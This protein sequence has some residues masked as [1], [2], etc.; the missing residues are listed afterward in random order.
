MSVQAELCSFCRLQERMHGLAS[1]PLGIAS[2][3]QLTA[4]LRPRSRQSQPCP[5]S[6]HLS[7]TLPL[8]SD[9][10]D[11][12]EPCQIIQNNLIPRSLVYSH[13]QNPCCPVRFH[14]H[15][16]RGLRCSRGGGVTLLPQCAQTQAF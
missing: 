5:V 9:P 15:R 16:F 6:S 3:P 12:T 8:S 4:H 1:P 13:L 7:P 10:C 2:A 11:Y 14:A